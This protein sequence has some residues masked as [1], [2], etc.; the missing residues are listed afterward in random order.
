MSNDLIKEKA[1]HATNCDE[2]NVRYGF[3]GL[4]CQKH[5]IELS[6]IR[7]VLVCAKNADLVPLEIIMRKK[8]I[9]LRKFTHYGHIKYLNH[10]IFLKELNFI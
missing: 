5:L 7:S 2:K 8:E 6:N 10:L 9:A 3:N 1:C 4:F